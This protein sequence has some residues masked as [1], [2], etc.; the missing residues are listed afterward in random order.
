MPLPPLDIEKK[1]EK[2]LKGLTYA[3]DGKTLM[4]HD[5]FDAW[6]LRRAREAKFDT[7]TR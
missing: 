2:D 4:P 5:G 3:W 7:P 6:V 1:I